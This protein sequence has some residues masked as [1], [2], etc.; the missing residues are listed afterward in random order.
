MII[1]GLI[2][3]CTYL[4]IRIT[5]EYIF[6]NKMQFPFNFWVYNTVAGYLTFK[7]YYDRVRNL[8]PIFER[9]GGV[10]KQ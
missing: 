10:I 4:S 8:S 1:Q 7:L 9:S 5:S 3:S 2:I 6:E